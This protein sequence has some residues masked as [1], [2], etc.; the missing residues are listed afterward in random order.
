[1]KHPELIVQIP[2]PCHEDW[3]K[4]SPTE[5][6]KFCNICTKE[7]VDFTSKSDEELVTY[8]T[9]N[10]NLCGRFDASQ[11]NRKLIADR[12]K[13]NHWLSY[14][15]TFLLP[16]T[17]VSQETKTPELKNTDT[18]QIDTS[19]FK[20]LKISS[21]DRKA[22]LNST[23]QNDSITVQGVV[24]DESGLP[25]PGAIVQIKGTN[26]GATTDF[27]GHYSIKSNYGTILVIS[28]VGYEI[29]KI[30][31][32]SS[33]INVQLESDV[34]GLHFIGA[35]VTESPNERYKSKF[36][37]KSH[38]KTDKKLNER[39]Q[40]TQNYFAFQRKKWLEKRD[41]RRAKRAAKKV[42]K[43]ATKK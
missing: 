42:E 26:I 10:G 19:A 30:K 17:L 6:G 41:E 4:M 37:K 1:M 22:K 9:N 3:N 20:S 5:K 15:A 13:R 21:L 25:L 31:I 33:T 8:F 27:D 39:E 29:K 23:M 35:V 24:T 28:Y 14:A 43:Q 11:L 38:P 2:E 40:R 12:K 36:T 32:T 18:E 34:Q 16:I 7:V